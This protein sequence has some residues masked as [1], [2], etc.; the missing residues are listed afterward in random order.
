MKWKLLYLLI[1]VFVMLLVVGCS[2]N[3]DVENSEIT[4]EYENVREV[5]WEFIKEKGWNDTAKEDWESAEV[6]NVIADNNYELLDNT[7]EGKELLVVS[8]TDKENVVVGTPS[9]LV[10]P[11][12]NE[13]VGYMPGE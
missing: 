6:K 7:Y 12:N 11:E 3:E 1:T 10:D 4:D 9:I 8:F 13:V 5:A 2:N